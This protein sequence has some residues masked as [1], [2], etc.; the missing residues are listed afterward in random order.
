VDGLN[1][2]P[3]GLVIAIPITTKEKVGIPFHVQLV[4]P[5]GGLPRRSWAKTEDV[6]SIS[7]ERL[8][9]RLGSVS[10]QTMDAIEDRLRVLL[11]L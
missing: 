8:S 11:G 9:S 6:R 3:S 4:P 5:E 1:A 2:G 10:L 7:V